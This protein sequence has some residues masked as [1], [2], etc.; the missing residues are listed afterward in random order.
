MA[1]PTPGRKSARVARVGATAGADA[2]GSLDDAVSARIYALAS[3]NSALAAEVRAL[4]AANADVAARAVGT[5]PS[6]GRKRARVE[7]PPSLGE[8]LITTTELNPKPEILKRDRNKNAL[9][10]VIARARA[11][12]APAAPAAA[13]APAANGG[14]GAVGGASA[15]GGN[16]AVGGAS[17]NGGNGAVGGASANGGNGAVGGASNASPA[18]PTDNTSAP[19]ENNDSPG[20]GTQTPSPTTPRQPITGK[21]P[22]TEVLGW[23][24]EAR[25][26]L[27]TDYP[28]RT[29]VE[30]GGQF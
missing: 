4:K 8:A 11:A 14:N 26:K 28:E 16:G 6:A 18:P 13:A 1:L 2:V 23:I 27:D 22:R 10:S 12:A 25:T 19:P 20:S 17:A 30:R 24:E 29:E 15:N 9:W 5:S 7:D 3:E 21:R